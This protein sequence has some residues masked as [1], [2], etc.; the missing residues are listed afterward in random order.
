M[1]QRRLDLH[2]LL[3][4]SIYIFPTNLYSNR[5]DAWKCEYFHCPQY[6]FSCQK[7]LI[8]RKCPNP[9]M[10]LQC[11]RI[12]NHVEDQNMRLYK[13]SYQ[14][15]FIWIEFDKTRWFC[16][17]NNDE[18]CTQNSLGGWWGLGVGY[19]GVV[20]VKEI[21]GGVLMPVWYE[22]DPLCMT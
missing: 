22:I 19:L 20:G 16:S 1:S 14:F 10:F 18:N 11:V 5:L 7:C 4:F 17:C 2:T 13:W 6:K 21:R 15:K 9:L 8:N 12:E 3:N